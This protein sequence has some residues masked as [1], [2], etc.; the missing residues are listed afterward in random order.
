MEHRAVVFTFYRL[1]GG[2]QTELIRCCYCL[3]S[4]GGMQLRYPKNRNAEV[5]ETKQQNFK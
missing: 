5:S 3:L 1:A 2:N 4:G